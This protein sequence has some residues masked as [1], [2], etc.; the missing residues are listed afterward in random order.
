MIFKKNICIFEKIITP[1]F[2]ICFLSI[3]FSG[4]SYASYKKNHSKPLNQEWYRQ[5]PN[6]GEIAFSAQNPL[7][8]E[9][10]ILF[11]PSMHSLNFTQ[12]SPLIQQEMEA[13]DILIAERNLPKHK[14]L[15]MSLNVRDIIGYCFAH[16][17]I[18]G[19]MDAGVIRQEAY[20]YNQRPWVDSITLQAKK[21]LTENFMNEKMLAGMHPKL[22]QPMMSCVARQ[23]VQKMGMDT[24]ILRKFDAA[25]KTIYDLDINN[26]N[27][28]YPVHY[29]LALYQRFA[30]LPIVKESLD[31]ISQSVGKII[32]FNAQSPALQHINNMIL[33]MNLAENHALYQTDSK[34]D[35]RNK[36]WIPKLLDY[37]A[38]N[39]HKKIVVVVG[40][41]HFHG[42]NGLLKLLEAKGFKFNE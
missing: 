32:E 24:V 1:I 26:D 31:D 40:A 36:L 18:S 21:F 7:N 16:E 38:N 12:I 10:E 19:L 2:F 8:A 17:N 42:N 6:P 27:L 14:P 41:A 39:P 15:L 34:T 13:A 23:E 9:Q 5:A 25:G 11:V 29:D 3:W 33:L 35:V 37:F 28:L 30:Q 20:L 4:E 22:I